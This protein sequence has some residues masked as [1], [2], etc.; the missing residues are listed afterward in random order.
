MYTHYNYYV[1]KKNITSKGYSITFIA[2]TK[3]SDIYYN[4]ESL[5]FN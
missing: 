3:T 2:E 1:I 5:F 4:L